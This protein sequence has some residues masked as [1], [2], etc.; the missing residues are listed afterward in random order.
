MNRPDAGQL[1]AAEARG[2]ALY[3]RILRYFAPD[4]SLITAL[5]ILIWVALGVG[6]SSRSSWPS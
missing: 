5:V 2:P 1:A 3:R 4:R 6:R